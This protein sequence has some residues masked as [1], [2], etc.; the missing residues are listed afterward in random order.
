MTAP[1]RLRPATER[2]ARQLLAKGRDP[3]DI[4]CRLQVP[5][6]AVQ[7]LV[8]EQD[9]RE[10]R[11]GTARKAPSTSE[12]RGSGEPVVGAAGPVV[13]VQPAAPLHQGEDP[14]RSG[15]GGSSPDE[16]QAK[17]EE[18]KAVGECTAAADDAGSRASGGASAAAPMQC[19]PDGCQLGEGDADGS[20]EYPSEPSDLRAGHRGR[21]SSPPEIG[22]EASAR[23]NAG[24]DPDS[25]T[26]GRDR[27][28]DSNVVPF[29]AL[30]P[31]HPG[32][33]AAEVFAGTR[34]ARAFGPGEGVGMG[35][36]RRGQCCWPLWADGK[37]PSFRFCGAPT[38][39]GGYCADHARRA[40]GRKVGGL[41]G[42]ASWA[43][44][45]GA[46]SAPD[47]R[48]GQA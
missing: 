25:V 21:T 23:A 32:V 45:I 22:R 34:L 44:D 7:R 37:R 39:R 6:Q 17:P 47:R 1:A 18:A 36:H 43:S 14:D 31:V 38:D 9:T 33:P 40:D 26:A 20:N 13:G 16:P 11:S 28:P 4:A 29:P 35:D 24:A 46:S 30:P 12:G 15:S 10:E 19:S 42:F 3:V 27:H 48:R 8:E 5:F 2:W 41:S